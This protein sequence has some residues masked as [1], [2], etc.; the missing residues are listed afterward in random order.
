MFIEYS[1]KHANIL[2]TNLFWVTGKETT[3]VDGR[4]HRFKIEAQKPR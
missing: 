4:E 2:L 1:L 3:C